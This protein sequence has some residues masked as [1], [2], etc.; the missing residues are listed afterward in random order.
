MLDCI[1]IYTIWTR[2]HTYLYVIY[3]QNIKGYWY[4]NSHLIQ[5]VL[6]IIFFPLSE[7][8]HIITL[9]LSTMPYVPCALICIS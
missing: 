1:Y 9:S 7:I 4:K 3:Q 6:F 8:Y 5:R 2:L